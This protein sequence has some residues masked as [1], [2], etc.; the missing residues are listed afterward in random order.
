MCLSQLSAKA[1][2]AELE[3]EQSEC[4]AEEEHVNYA[5]RASPLYVACGA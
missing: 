2:E 5:A 1:W 4:R 3:R